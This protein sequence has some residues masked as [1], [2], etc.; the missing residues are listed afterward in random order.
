VGRLTLAR[1]RCSDPFGHDTL[2]CRSFWFPRSL[3]PS[4]FLRN[5][6]S[7]ASFRDFERCGTFGHSTRSYRTSRKWT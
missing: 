2:H 3:A 5:A 4:C 7:H 6:P 1:F